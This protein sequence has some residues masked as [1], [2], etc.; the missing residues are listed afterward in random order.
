MPRAL[1]G[2]GI[3]LSTDFSNISV[4]PNP[5]IDRINVDLSN[6]NTETEEV[7]IGIYDPK[8]AEIMTKIISGSG[9][10]LIDLSYF[11]ATAYQ[12]VIKQGLET[13]HQS[14]II[15]VK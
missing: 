15:K 5:T 9:I 3:N 8:G 11:P 7:K 4:Y 6:I 2:Y 14:S 10:E 1:I 12:I 13:I